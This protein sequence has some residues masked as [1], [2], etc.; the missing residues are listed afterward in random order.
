MM[1]ARRDRGAIMTVLGKI[2]VFL[3]FIAALAMGGLMAYSYK[4]A[5]Q[6]KDAVKERDDKLEVFKAMARQE[7]ESRRKLI[8]D[9]EKLKRLLDGKS[10]EGNAKFIEVEQESKQSKS[11]LVAAMAQRDEAVLQATRSADE[12]KRLDKELK[13]TMG[14]V[15]EREKS[16]LKLQDEI[17]KAINDKQAAENIAQTATARLQSLYE[18]LKA[19]ETIIAELTKKN[20]PVTPGSSPGG[21]GPKDASYSNP[22][23]V[24]VKGQIEKVDT[25]DKTLVKITIGSDSGL[26]KDHTLEVYRL[27]PKAEYLGRLLIVDADF[28]YAFGKL[29]RQPGVA[30]PTLQPG[31]EVATK[32][33]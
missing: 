21:G 25:T 1:L 20:Q 30:P 7:A 19:K 10:L 6:W 11:Q 27:A 32:L 18:Q 12:S 5:P 28:R 2:L 29:L 24:M 9:N 13:F 16:I 3:V 26:K 33:R 17:A 31:D 23:A 8:E 14:V 4:F 22:P 15:Q